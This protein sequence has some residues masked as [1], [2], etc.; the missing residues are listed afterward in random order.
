M[1]GCQRISCGASLGAARLERKDG[2][3]ASAPTAVW[4]QPYPEKPEGIHVT[5]PL[6]SRRGLRVRANPGVCP[7][8][9]VCREALLPPTAGHLADGMWGRAWGAG[10][11]QTPTSCFP[12]TLR[13]RDHT[14]CGVGTSQ[15]QLEEQGV[16]GGPV[17][18]GRSAILH[19][20]VTCVS[21]H[22]HMH[23]A[24]PPRSV[25]GLSPWLTSPTSV[26]GAGKPGSG[27]EPLPWFTPLHR[28]TSR[29]R[30]AFVQG[31][32]RAARWAVVPVWVPVSALELCPWVTGSQCQ[33]GATPPPPLQRQS[34]G[35]SGE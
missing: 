9:A 17:C 26:T 12:G 16:G 30:A 15:V 35:H 20:K 10:D 6:G 4:L 29:P 14:A 22:T 8:S 34:L 27:G 19:G 25:L 32:S 28:V 31:G 21:V 2:G 24:Q 18:G 13:A 1:G 33:H 7:A 5:V 23:T 11:L 3:P